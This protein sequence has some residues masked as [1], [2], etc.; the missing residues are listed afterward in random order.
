MLQGWYSSYMLQ[1]VKGDLKSV[2][3]VAVGHVLWFLH[4]KVGTALLSLP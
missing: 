3:H 4:V 1:L 2:F